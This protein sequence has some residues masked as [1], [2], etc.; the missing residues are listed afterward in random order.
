MALNLLLSGDAMLGRG[1]NEVLLE[2][3]PEYPLGPV[4]PLTRAAGLFFTNLEC[5]ITPK[6]R[7]Y[8]GPPKAFYFRADPIA[9]DALAYAG[10]HL[11]SLAN[12]H[13]L[14]AD[15]EGLLDTL[16]ILEQKGIRH[17]GAGHDLEAASRPAL[18]ERGGM[19]LGV[20]AYC[21][22][23]P[24]FAARE[25]RPGIRY[26]D[27]TDPQTLERLSVEVSVMAR[28]VDHLII[29]FHWQPNWAAQVTPNY[30]SLARLLVSS[31]ARLI[32][33]HSPHHFQGVEWFGQSAVIYSSGGL[34]DDYALEPTYRNDRQLLFQAD[35]DNA[36]VQ[37][38]A[39]FPIELKYARTIPARP[40]A[41][42]W[43]RRR[44]GQAC[45]Q[46]GSRVEA[47][48]DWLEVLPGL[49]L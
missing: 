40:N 46:V 43:I 41:R 31:G 38:I 36:G 1:V 48:G 26:V 35:L 18:I 14:D 4:A 28:Q 29:A 8:S 15:P 32:W 42:R 22:H 27:L 25:D 21:D 11:V 9:A 30:R 12:N 45:A 23:Q 17:A 5:A 19:T 39:A 44:F 6:D 13:A 33:G 7:V 49:P 10:V 20:A 3:G 34:V 24:D 16:S 2:T 47:S 37:R